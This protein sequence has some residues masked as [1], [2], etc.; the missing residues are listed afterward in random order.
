M[1]V[2]GI[3]IDNRVWGMMVAKFSW[4]P[5]LSGVEYTDEES[6]E[7]KR[8]TAE[9]RYETL[10]SLLEK[11]ALCI[12]AL[13][14]GQATIIPRLGDEAVEGDITSKIDLE[15]LKG[16]YEEMARYQRDMESKGKR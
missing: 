2:S 7:K 15:A 6:G 8:M 1:I 13:P 12:C 4:E 5:F 9:E 3:E 14:D 16:R 10:I 11:E